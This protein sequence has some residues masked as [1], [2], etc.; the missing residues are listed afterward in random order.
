[1]ARTYATVGQ[2]MT[3][4]YDEVVG[5]R[6]IREDGERDLLFTSL[7]GHLLEFVTMTPRSRTA[8]A[9]VLLDEPIELGNIVADPDID[10]DGADLSARI[11]P[12]DGHEDDGADLLVALSAE[13]AV[14]APRISALLTQLNPSPRSRLLVITRKSDRVGFTGPG[15]DR[16]IEVTWEKMRGKL[17]KADP[18][19]ADL[20]RTI[21]EIGLTVGLPV[22]QLPV[23]PSRLLNDAATA[24]EF[25]AHLDAFHRAC[26][27]LTGTTPRFSTHP[28]LSDAHLQAGDSRGR[29]G[30]QFGEVHDGSPISVVRGGEVQH[31]LGIALL[32]DRSER[33]AAE[34]LLAALHAR[35]PQR[36]RAAPEP[37]EMIGAPAAPQMEAVRRIL[38]AVLN[39]RLLREHGFELAPARQQPLLT[40]SLLGVRLVRPEDPFD[41][42]Y[43]ITVG[44]ARP[45]RSLV[46]RVERERT[47][48]LNRESYAVAP[49]KGQSTGDF[50]WEVHRALFSLTVP[51]RH[52][53]GR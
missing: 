35:D 10:R 40:K 42:T 26:R 16:V 2:M 7:C 46:P 44:G 27:V 32:A 5:A 1:M 20:W 14:D 23:D 37:A 45:W 9:H 51:V 43:T 4:A 12:E 15:A 33:R 19:H 41:V 36:I 31:Q 28:R 13:R 52:G 39:P 47:A 24:R 22:V 11:L 30:L 8:F 3:Y 18:G 21:A 17:A 29:W 53:A 25:R 6:G 38:W 50:V 49:R 48:A 34:D